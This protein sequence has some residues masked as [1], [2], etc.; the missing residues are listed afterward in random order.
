MSF[1]VKPTRKLDTESGRIKQKPQGMKKQIESLFELY[2]KEYN[3]PRK[4]NKWKYT[5]IIFCKP[6]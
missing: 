3:I 2:Y 4:Y 1:L 6:S 5:G